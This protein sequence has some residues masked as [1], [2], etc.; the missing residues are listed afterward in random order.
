MTSRYVIEI[1]P[2]SIGVALKAGTVVNDGRGFRFLAASR[3]FDALESQYFSSP[4]KA[5]EAALRRVA[6]LAAT[7]SPGARNGTEQQRVGGLDN[8]AALPSP[9]ER[10]WTDQPIGWNGG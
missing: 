2:A 3:A 10:H 8:A 5:E 7:I 9:F 6:M 1:R 4:E